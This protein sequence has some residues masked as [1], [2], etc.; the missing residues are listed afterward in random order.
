MD[1]AIVTGADTRFGDA[2]CRTL[3]K[4]GF[5]IHALGQ[6][7]DSSD[8]DSRYYHPHA[9][10]AGKL[11][12]LK[13]ALEDVL[14]E[15]G[16]L[17][18]LIGLG[19][20]EMTTGWENSTPEGLV[21]RLHGCL[22]EP[23]LAASVCLKA[24]KQSKGFLIHGHRRPV[25]KDLSISPG[26]FEDSMR[27]AYDELFIRNAESGLRSA[28]IL[29]AYP[30]EESD[31]EAIYQD[32]AD[33]V[34]RAFEIILRQ[35]E[36]CVIRE[37]HISPRGLGPVGVFPN[38]VTAMDPYQT[39][40]LPES[41]PNE[42]EPILIPTEKPKHYV[43]I[44]EVKDITSGDVEVPDHYED[45]VDDEL[46]TH[47]RRDQGE[48]GDGQSKS[49]RRRRSRGRGR[50]RKP[51]DQNG[52]D[53]QNRDDSSPGQENR[54]EPSQVETA[55]GN[56]EEP[57]KR[58]RSRRSRGS[59]SPKN[60]N[61]ESAENKSEAQPAPDSSSNEPAPQ[62]VDSSDP[63][64]NAESAPT[65]KPAKKPRPARKRTPRTSTAKPKESPPKEATESST[66]P[67]AAPAETSQPATEVGA[68]EKPAPKKRTARKTTR[69]RSTATARKK[70]ASA[71]KSKPEVADPPKEP[72]P[73]PSSSSD[74][75]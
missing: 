56:S 66:P 15:E 52:P 12:E 51:D 3:L 32:V 16:R 19:G 59:R 9:Y 24:L 27:R 57:R 1:V 46:D 45:E 49:K 35:K 74:P 23:L 39:T 11:A 30:E 42:L 58:S 65:E 71:P 17:D 20:P 69:K 4:M 43:Q 37:M 55:E 34:S 21:R 62:K 28:R 29:Y 10:G 63:E 54:E 73:T 70:T 44:A 13:N 31:S 18:L 61:E 75:E 26:Y 8:Y 38:L 72:E 7:P 33:S 40:I 53:N 5:R 68:E 6:N 22:T 47:R 60:Q 14:K 2:V 48:N 67:P 36:T 41:D 25:A 64:G 50:R